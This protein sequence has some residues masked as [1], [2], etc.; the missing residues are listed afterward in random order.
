MHEQLNAEKKANQKQMEKLETEN[1]SLKA[2][3]EDQ[4]L[5]TSL[6]MPS[7]SLCDFQN[8]IKPLVEKL[9]EYYQALQ[10]KNE[11]VRIF[12]LLDSSNDYLC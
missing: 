8:H 7:I 9:I 10:C 1:K 11:S 3:M 4:R 12:E 5:Q 2:W 6:Q